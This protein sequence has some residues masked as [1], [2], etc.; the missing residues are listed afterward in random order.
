MRSARGGARL[1]IRSVR[2]ICV[3]TCDHVCV[4]VGHVCLFACLILV[5]TCFW[6]VFFYI[7]CSRGAGLMFYNQRGCGV[8]G[9]EWVDL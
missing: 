7:V 5:D 2:V 6:A 8:A 3:R 9:G 4:C 1:T